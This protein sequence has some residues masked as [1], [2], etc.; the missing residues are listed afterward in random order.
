MGDTTMLVVDDE[1]GVRS[2][3]KGVLEDE[4]FQVFTAASGEEGLEQIE[5]V[6]PDIVLLDVMMPSGIDGIETLRRI[7]ASGSDTAVIMISGHGTIEMAVSA[8][9]LGA[10]D[11][12]EK[13]LSVERILIRLTQALDKKKLQ[14]ENIL[15]KKAVEERYQMIGEGLVMRDLAAKIEQIAPTNSRVLIMGENGTGKE[16]A[17]RA[18]HRNSGRSD[19]PFI[20][21]NCAAI[22]A[23]LI[24]SELF[25]HEKGAFTGAIAR[26]QGKFQQADGGTILLDEIGDMSLLTQ[27]KVL[28]VLEEQ[29]FTRIGGKDTIKIDVRVIAATNKDLNKEVQ[30]GRFRED[31]FYR[32]NVIPIYIPP[33]RE[34]VED[35]PLLGAY[36][37][38]IFC[39]ENGKREKT[40]SQEAMRLLQGYR[41]PGN[42]R[43]LR[44]LIERLVIMT[45]TDTIDISDLPD[46]LTEHSVP[47]SALALREARMQFENRFIRQALQQNGWNISETAR[48]L[49]IERTNLHRK[50][51]QHNISR[52]EKGG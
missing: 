11:F 34:R 50:M 2:S 36:F 46:N 5:K 23:E 44:N 51:K 20:Q 10:L 40:I 28:R 41:W 3:L 24:E 19:G 42:V 30:E 22:P 38:T 31:L 15:L 8:M 32:L 45:A 47:A 16:L 49:G 6:K 26:T 14:A 18:I 21:V 17:A 7:K 27:S 33:L 39:R 1:P 12:V 43:E 25:G 4:G 9:E 35:I 37:I 13:P 29:E 52:E 48:Q